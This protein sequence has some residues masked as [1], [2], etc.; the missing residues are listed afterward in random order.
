M[1]D[2]TQNNLTIHSDTFQVVKTQEVV[3]TTITVPENKQDKTKNFNVAIEVTAI[4]MIAI[5]GFMLIFFLV[6]KVIDKLFPDKTQ[7]GNPS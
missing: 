4:A 7:D 3:T 5:F 2:S 6:I 1:Q